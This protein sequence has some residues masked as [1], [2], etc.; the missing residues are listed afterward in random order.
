M[1]TKPRTFTEALNEGGHHVH[2][3]LHLMTRFLSIIVVTIAA[4]C[5]LLWGLQ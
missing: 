2:A 3:S 4:V 1:R 5:V